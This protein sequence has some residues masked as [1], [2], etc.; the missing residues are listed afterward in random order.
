[1]GTLNPHGPRTEPLKIKKTRTPHLE[2]RIWRSWALWA[3]RFRKVQSSSLK[4]WGFRVYG[5]E[6]LGFGVLGFRI[7]GLGLW[8]FRVLVFWGFR[9][10]SLQ[11]FL[12][13]IITACVY[14]IFLVVAAS[15]QSFTVQ[16][17]RQGAHPCS[18]SST[19]ETAGRVLPSQVWRAANELCRESI[20]CDGV[21]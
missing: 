3:L 5:V 7:Q 10:Q 21:D 15:V 17:W 2:A 1:M 9:V 4:V 12:N 16:G 18:T 19:A 20:H 11:W 8:G 14:I 13:G 6:G